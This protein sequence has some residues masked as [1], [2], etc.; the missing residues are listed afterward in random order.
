MVYIA[1]GVGAGVLFLIII[2]VFFV[3]VFDIIY[4]M[5]VTQEY[6]QLYEHLH[7]T[8]LCLGRTPKPIVEQALNSKIFHIFWMLK[9][10][11]NELKKLFWITY[12]IKLNQEEFLL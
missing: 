12:H 6:H 7:I 2:V 11:E 5:Q 8:Y 9:K 1:S 3:V 10:R 4:T